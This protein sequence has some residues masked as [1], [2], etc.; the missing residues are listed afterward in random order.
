MNDAVVLQP[1]TLELEGFE[2]RGTRS[3]ELKTKGGTFIG[4]KT[5]TPG[6]STELYFKYVK[7]KLTELQQ[8]D[9]NKRITNLQVMVKGSVELGQ[10]GLYEELTRML[11]VMIRE[12]E[13]A[14]AGYDWFLLKKDID[15]FIGIVRNDKIK[16]VDLKTFARV[17]PEEPAEKI[18]AAQEFFDSIWILATNPEVNETNKEKIRK[19]DPIAFGKF[20]Y[21][22]DK[23][24]FIADWIDEFCDVTLSKVTEL[25]K[26]QVDVVPE[27]T[28]D[29]ACEIKNEVMARH[30]RLQ[31][32]SF[33]N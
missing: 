20:A 30:D 1:N 21:E 19:K 27:I 16:L 13:V 17:I 15:K 22:P 4:L 14:A 2:I 10:D 29:R 31:K 26:K 5:E 7:S 25:I 8:E 6:I 9:L 33:N 28:F 12:Q 23:Y 18:K 24:Y 11:A 3:K 32:T